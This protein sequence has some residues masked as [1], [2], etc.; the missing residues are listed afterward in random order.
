MET[1][2]SGG[3]RKESVMREHRT[4]N[5]EHRTSNDVV[6]SF[7]VQRSMFNIQRSFGFTLVEL[8]VVMAIITI[9]TALLLPVLQKAR[10]EAQLVSCTSNLKQVFGGHMFYH[11]D[12]S[13]FVVAVDFSNGLLVSSAGYAGTWYGLK[14]AY[15]EPYYPRVSGVY[16]CPG[17][18]PCAT[19]RA[20]SSWYTGVQ[21]GSGAMMRLARFRTTNDA[22]KRYS[23]QP[24]TYDYIQGGINTADTERASVWHGNAG[25]VPVLMTDGRAYIWRAPIEVIIPWGFPTG[26]H[27]GTEYSTEGVA[28]LRSMCEQ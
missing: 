22:C 18:Q 12:Y 10:Q 28:S 20:Q 7:D 23:T 19:I 11:D 17:S 25:R 24:M 6:R 8:L 2:A 1:W 3:R 5:I 27:Q 13:G 21:V 14:H 4:A 16:R 9:L 15:L 26:T